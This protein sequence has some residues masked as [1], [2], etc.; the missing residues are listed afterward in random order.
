MNKKI[1]RFQPPEELVKALGSAN[2]IRP[3][4]REA[5]AAGIWFSMV[6]S[7]TSPTNESVKIITR[8]GRKVTLDINTLK[9]YFVDAGVSYEKFETAVTLEG[10]RLFPPTSMH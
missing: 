7:S 2:G 10:L 3:S 9:Q 1:Q 4:R 8:S 6:S 5:L